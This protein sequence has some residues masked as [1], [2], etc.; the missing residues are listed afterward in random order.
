ML[1]R[2]SMA[3]GCV[4]TATFSSDTVDISARWF[5]TLEVDGGW[6]WKWWYGVTRSDVSRRIDCVMLRDESEGLGVYGA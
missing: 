3:G 5:V 1:G 2:V 4:L 6:V